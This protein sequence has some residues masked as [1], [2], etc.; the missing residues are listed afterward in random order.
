MA[1]DFMESKENIED[2]ELELAENSKQ[3]RK[4][5]KRK[6]M[7]QYYGDHFDEM[8]ATRPKR[9]KLSVKQQQLQDLPEQ[10]LVSGTVQSPS[11]YCH[12]AERSSNPKDFSTPS[13]D[14]PAV[15]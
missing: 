8:P 10:H 14:D 6:S 3:K 1:V 11:E 13:N 4:A 5:P 2:D 7:A 12:P 15:I 9:K